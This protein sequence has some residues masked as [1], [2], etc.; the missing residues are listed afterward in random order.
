MQ[1]EKQM[2]MWVVSIICLLVLFRFIPHAP[3]FT[4]VGAMA[5]LGGLWI[6]NLRL[7]MLIP[8]AAMLISDT[9]LG[10]HSTLIYVYAAFAFTVA[11]GWWLSKYRNLRAVMIGAIGSSVLFFLVTNFGAWLHHDMYPQTPDGLLQAY[12]AGLPFFRNTLVS[13]LLFSALGHFVL[14]GL[15]RVIGT[16]KHMA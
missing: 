13:M 12:A 6:A 3:N 15:D 1:A 9:V 4:P 5:L 7:A 11:L 16:K 10:F 2:I 14:A 8:L